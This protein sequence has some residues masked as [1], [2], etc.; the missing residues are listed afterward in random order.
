MLLELGG[1]VEVDVLAPVAGAPLPAGD[2]NAAGV[3]LRLRHGAVALLLAAD[4]G[5]AQELALARGP[6]E[7]ASAGLKVAHH[8][9][10]TS[11]TDLLLHRTRPAVAVISVGEGN[12]F[13]HP[14]PE[15]LA[16]LDGTVVL[17]TDEDGAVRLRS[18]GRTLRYSAA[19]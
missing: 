8:G 17:R 11:T 12:G 16:R 7:L 3:V 5:A 1:G 14:R 9:S 4:V 2:L 10:A 19:R 6:W 18:D 13:G 15:V